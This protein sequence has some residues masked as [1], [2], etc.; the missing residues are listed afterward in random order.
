MRVGRSLRAIRKGQGL[1]LEELSALSGV[2]RDDLG[3][4]ERGEA[5]PRP[6]TVRRI[7]G[8]LGVPIV[9]I[10]GGMGWTVSGAVE[11]WEREEDLLL[12]GIREDLL[13]AE[14]WE[15]EEAEVRAL[16]EV[17][18]ATIPALVDR[19]KDTRPETEI[20]RG[21]LRELDTEDDVGERW[22][23]TEEQWEQVRDLLP[24]ERAGRGRA[25]KSNRL[26][27]D[28]I[29]YQRKTGAAWRSLP[30]RFGRGKCV[31]DR[32]KLWERTGVWPPVR[33]KLRELG[34]LD[35]VSGENIEM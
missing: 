7:A 5:T 27:L 10:S 30:E 2:H 31:S 33:E 20:V 4:Y 3:K 6:E 16:L 11:P 25:F 32:L 15:P 21:L 1:T 35:P 29:V 34:V 9:S 8:A 12:A 19:M 18:K 28:G 14:D 23:L 17:V 22:A 13:R 26:M 24:P